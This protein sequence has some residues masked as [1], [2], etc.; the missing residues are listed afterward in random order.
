[1]KHVLIILALATAASAQPVE[2][3]AAPEPAPQPP[4]VVPPAPPPPAAQPAPAVADDGLPK[5]PP[6]KRFM[7]G[8]RLGWMYVFKLR[9]PTRDNGMSLATEYKLKSPNMFVIGYELFY[10]IVSHSWLD[11]L[12][13]GNVTVSGLEQSKFIPAASG[14]LGFEFNRNFELGVGINLTPD[15]QAPTH[16]IVAAGWT[17]FVGSIQTPVHFFFIPDTVGNHRMGATIGMSW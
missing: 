13:V 10:R 12:M 4:S 3:A 15:P 17:P 1:M 2:P 5:Q 7:H 6:G 11:V 14:L 16:M 8:F 9:E